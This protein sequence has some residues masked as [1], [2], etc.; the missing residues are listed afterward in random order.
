MYFYLAIG[1]LITVYILFLIWLYREQPTDF[2][3][4][5]LKIPKRR[6][7]I[8]VLQ[9]CSEHLETTK[10]RYDLKIHYYPNK[11]FGG[12]FQSFNKQIIIYIHPYLR[13]EDLVD[14]V[15]H[16]YVHHLQFS[17]VSTEQEYNKKLVEVGYWDNPYE[18]EARKLAQQHKKKCLD[19][20]LR[21]N[22]LC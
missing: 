7:V 20:I 17:T 21:H 4:R 19:W 2:K 22:K 1:F 12:K 6:F 16:E 13:L 14:I 18:V 10:H 8:I 15:I 3:V 5:D 11:K 9:W